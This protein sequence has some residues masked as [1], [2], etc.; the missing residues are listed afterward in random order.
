MAD[1]GALKS[2]MPGGTLPIWVDENG[3]MLGQSISILQAF[4]RKLGYTPKGFLGDWANQW[5]S[6]TIADF[7]AKGYTGK[8]FGPAV[9][10]ATV[11][12]WAADNMKLNL[13]IEKHLAL[14]KS[15]FL[16]G[17]NLTASD[18]HLYALVYSFAL[19]KNCN[20][21]NVQHALQATHGTSETPLLNAWVERMDNELKDYMAKRPAYI[22]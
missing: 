14:M 3:L 16:A 8:L 11:K 13:S 4:A 22:L 1:W 17:D 9:D 21:P 19:N 2:E 15:K 12:A 18:F 20:H 10:E 7:Q 5:V 6:D